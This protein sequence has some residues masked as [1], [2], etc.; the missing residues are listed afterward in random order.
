MVSPRARRAHDAGARLCRRLTAASVI[1]LGLASCAPARPGLLV[2]PRD[3]SQGASRPRIERVVELGG[4]AVRG[5][6]QPLEAGDG[7]A[8]VGEALWL[9]GPGFG[10]Q[11]T[12]RLGGEVTPVLGFTADGGLVVR[13]PAG[14]ATGRQ[15]LSVRTA[16]G[17]AET[18]VEVKRFAAAWDA[19][20]QLSWVDAGVPAPL[21]GLAPSVPLVAHLAFSSDGRAAYVVGPDGRRLTVVDMTAQGG[22][23]AVFA[24]ELEG[25]PVLGLEASRGAPVLAL[26]REEDVMVLDTTEALRPPRSRPRP[27]PPE[28]R[29]GRPVGAA[30]SPDGQHLAVALA[31]SG[32]V[33]LLALS[34]RADARLVAHEKVDTAVSAPPLVD[35]SFSPDGRTLWVLSGSTPKT[36]EPSLGPAHVT[37]FSVAGSLQAPLT[38]ARRFA[39]GEASFP[40]ALAVSPARPLPSGA[41]IRTPPVEAQVFVSAQDQGEAGGGLFAVAAAATPLLATLPS[42][43]TASMV[44][45]R[46][47]W[48]FTCVAGPGGAELV[49]VRANER[50][51]T[52]GRAPI[53]GLTSGCR[54]E[55]QP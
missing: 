49:W 25:T 53:K 7:V 16:A 2:P 40:V 8:V 44:D 3:L 41:A 54:L 34:D 46:G 33:A 21:A 11:P 55:G 43:P 28:V 9:R 1:A 51:T 13:V 38:G 4:A 39:L 10:R 47:Q 27:L 50:P 20:G 45:A 19:A 15:A 24:L 5:E 35:L 26:V 36:A 29:A 37:A 32:H 18:V 48:V 52:P 22:P 31:G 12:V 23:R 6:V 17:Q 14:A 42:P 30:L